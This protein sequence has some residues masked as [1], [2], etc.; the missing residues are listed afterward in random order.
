MEIE[1]RKTA[2]AVRAM[3]VKV[4]RW[5]SVM[6]GTSRR[7]PSIVEEE[8]GAISSTSS[9]HS[10]IPRREKEQPAGSQVLLGEKKRQRIT[11]QRRLQA[12]A[13]G[14]KICAS[15]RVGTIS[16]C[17]VSAGQRGTIGCPSTWKTARSHAGVPRDAACPRCISV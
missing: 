14:I 11:E 9:R 17:I 1:L 2:V 13:A 6:S 12:P 7:R 3:S 5:I 10:I 8:G 16:D 4:A 15:T